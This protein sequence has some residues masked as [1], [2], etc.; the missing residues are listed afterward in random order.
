MLNSAELEQIIRILKIWPNRMGCALVPNAK[1]KHGYK[2]IDWGWKGRMFGNFDY[3]QLRALISERSDI[4]CC[5]VTAIGLMRNA[6]N[7]QDHMSAYKD[8][9]AKLAEI[10]RI[11]EKEAQIKY[12]ALLKT[13]AKL[14]AFIFETHVSGVSK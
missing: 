9:R 10:L 1:G 7:F 4:L 2:P 12:N 6:Q 11:S 3:A 13:D 8:I 14:L 5:P